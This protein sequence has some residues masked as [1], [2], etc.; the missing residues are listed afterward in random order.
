MLQAI[1]IVDKNGHVD[2]VLRAE[3]E[4][5]VLDINYSEKFKRWLDGDDNVSFS[6]EMSESGVN[7]LLKR[8][9]ELL[10]EHENL[11]ALA[12]DH[13]MTHE[14]SDLSEVEEATDA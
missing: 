2:P 14:L 10:E 1:G 12:E 7:D 6:E 3:A 11:K 13:V 9:I 8:R 5:A 4:Q